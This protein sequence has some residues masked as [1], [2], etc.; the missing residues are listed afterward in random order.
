MNRPVWYVAATVPDRDRHG[1]PGSTEQRGHGCRSTSS[2][3]AVGVG[4]GSRLTYSEPPSMAS[5]ALR[6][7]RRPTS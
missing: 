4:S 1:E 3:L 7:L 2:E 5:I 6:R